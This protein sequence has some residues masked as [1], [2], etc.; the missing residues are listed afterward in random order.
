MH[1]FAFKFKLENRLLHHILVNNRCNSF[2]FLV[3]DA[4]SEPKNPTRVTA[5]QHKQTSELFDLF[6]R[7]EDYSSVDEEAV[8]IALVTSTSTTLAPRSNFLFAQSCSTVR[9]IT[10]LYFFVLYV[11]HLQTLAAAPLDFP[12]PPVACDCGK[13]FRS[14]ASMAATSWGSK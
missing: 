6:L 5:K 13:N 9:E 10:F 1:Q 2:F 12:L 8:T 3:T 7:H 4:M 14:V 11:E